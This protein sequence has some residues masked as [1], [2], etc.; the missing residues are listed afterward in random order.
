MVIMGFFGELM[1]LAQRNMVPLRDQIL[2]LLMQSSMLYY[3]AFALPMNNIK[4]L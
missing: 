2:D 3:Q 4:T 1:L